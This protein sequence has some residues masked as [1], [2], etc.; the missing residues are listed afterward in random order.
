MDYP[1]LEPRLNVYQTWIRRTVAYFCWL[2]RIRSN[3]SEVQK[4]CKTSHWRKWHIFQRTRHYRL[5]HYPNEEGAK[6]RRNRNEWSCCCSAENCRHD[7]D[8]GDGIQQLWHVKSLG[9]AEFFAAHSAFANEQY[10]ISLACARPIRKLDQCGDFRHFRVTRWSRLRA[11]VWCES[12]GVLQ[13]WF[14]GIRLW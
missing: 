8:I 3:G 12:D 4:C 2:H 6:V 10:G 9:R 11:W 13:R 7:T 14:W 5:I 1:E